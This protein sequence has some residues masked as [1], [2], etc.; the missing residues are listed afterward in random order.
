MADSIWPTALQ[1]QPKIA[2]DVKRL[3]WESFEYSNDKIYLF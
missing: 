2:E 3:P 1:N